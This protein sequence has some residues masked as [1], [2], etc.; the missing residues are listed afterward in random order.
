MATQLLW[1][2][3]ETPDG[4]FIPG[5]HGTSAESELYPGIS[6]AVAFIISGG[7]AL[8]MDSGYRPRPGYTTGVLDRICEILDRRNLRLKYIVQTHWHF[9]H[10]AGTQHVKKRYGAEVLCHPADRAVIEDPM[11][12]SRPEYMESLGGSVTAAAEDLNLEDAG[13]LLPEENVVRDYWDFPVEVDGTIENGDVLTVGEVE[14]R[15]LHTPGHTPGHLCLYT[16]GSGSLY[17]CDVMYWPAPSPPYPIGN[18]EDQIES[19]KKC[20]ALDAEY[21][22]P[23]HDL[24]RCG[25]HDSRDY[26]QDLLVKQL[27]LELRILTL[28]NRHGPLTVAELHAETFVTKDRYDYPNNGWWTKSIN[29]VYGQLLRLQRHG[30]VDRVSRADGNVAWEATETARLSEEDVSVVGGYERSV[31]RLEESL[32]RHRKPARADLLQQE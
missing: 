28:L 18:S 26:L 13:I 9:D 10:T 16:P 14:V 7:E 17:L 8:M 15:V 27:Q 5:P 2:T 23:G 19:I 22:F 4:L 1:G 20:L 32:E 12:L 11:L 24:P 21:V 31:R 30:K 29:C 6:S 3:I 25:T